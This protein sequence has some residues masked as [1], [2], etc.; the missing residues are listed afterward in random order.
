VGLCGTDME[1]CPIGPN[2]A[3]CVPGPG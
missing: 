3:I 1:S 2:D